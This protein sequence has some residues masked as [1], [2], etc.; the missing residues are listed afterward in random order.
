MTPYVTIYHAENSRI[1]DGDWGSIS[2]WRADNY[3]K[4]EVMR[5]NRL[6]MH[7]VT[8]DAVGKAIAYAL[9]KFGWQHFLASDIRVERVSLQL[10][11]FH[12]E[13]RE[14]VELSVDQRNKLFRFLMAVVKRYDA[15]RNHETGVLYLPD[16]SPVYATASQSA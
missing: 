4:I 7:P 3:L 9:P 12:V 13:N 16:G 11:A 8:M 15:Q 1:Y 5:C 10:Y 14:S 2:I 6:T